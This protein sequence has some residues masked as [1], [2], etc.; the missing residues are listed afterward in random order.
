MSTEKSNTG[1]GEW[2]DERARI[3]EGIEAAP[4]GELRGLLRDFALENQRL[5]I[6]LEAISGQTGE[7]WGVIEMQI[8]ERGKERGVVGLLVCSPGDEAALASR[9]LKDFEEHFNIT[10]VEEPTLTG[11]N[12]VRGGG[13]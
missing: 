12:S 3:I 8:I 9:L 10:E 5:R 6:M 11:V 4:E 13:R 1:V 2:G 7:T